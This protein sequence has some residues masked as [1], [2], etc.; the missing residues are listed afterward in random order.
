MEL[1]MQGFNYSIAVSDVENL[2]T[3]ACS[4]TSITGGY[5]G[6]YGG[7][8]SSSNVSS[9]IRNT[10]SDM[11]EQLQK[12]AESDGVQLVQTEG[13][14][15]FGAG[16]VIGNDDIMLCIPT[17]FSFSENMFNQQI[18][19]YS[20]DCEIS[21]CDKS[22]VEIWVERVP[23]LKRKL[24]CDFFQMEIT[25]A[26]MTNRIYAEMVVDGNTAILTM[27]YG[28]R[29]SVIA[30][31]AILLHSGMC[32]FNIKIK[33]NSNFVNTDSIVYRICNSIKFRRSDV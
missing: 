11:G 31:A 8:Y 16:K 27:E 28:N 9:Q 24:I 15:N 32:E 18:I 5:D 10:K 13:Y 7:G 20:S 25:K 29:S 17:S 3:Q 4:K 1:N 23:L 26:Y 33:V 19:A 12:I 6:T 22:P 21:T 30:R 2:D 14:F